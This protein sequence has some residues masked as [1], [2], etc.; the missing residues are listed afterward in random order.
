MSKYG[1]TNLESGLMNNDNKV[2]NVVKQRKL[3]VK[4]ILSWV[5]GFFGA[6]ILGYFVYIGWK[7]L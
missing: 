2:K 3:P 6:I 1:I 5:L 4:Y 7:I